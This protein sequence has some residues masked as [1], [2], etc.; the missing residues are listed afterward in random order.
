MLIWPKRGFV[1]ETWLEWLFIFVHHA[2]K[3]EKKSL[4]QIVIHRPSVFWATIPKKL[5]I[6]PKKGFL[7]KS[8]SVD[9]YRDIVPYHAAK[10]K[11][12]CSNKSWDITLCNVWPYSGL[13]SP[14]G[15]RRGFS[16]NL[17]FLCKYYPLSC[18]KIWKKCLETV[19]M[20]ELM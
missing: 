4:E 6:W 9:F 14:F 5:S 3:F 7:G 2:A 20:Y 13:N 1:W 15:H 11:K 16:G 18:Y 17:A 12:N 10:F 8:Y 19:L